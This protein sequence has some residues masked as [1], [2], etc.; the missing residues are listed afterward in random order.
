MVVKKTSSMYH[1]GN[2][3]LLSTEVEFPTCLCTVSDTGLLLRKCDNL[4]EVSQVN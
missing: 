4:L 1:F 2:S 3:Q